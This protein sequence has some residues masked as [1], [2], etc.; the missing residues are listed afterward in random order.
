MLCSALQVGEFASK[1]FVQ[2][3]LRSP[4]TPSAVI[5]FFYGV[6]YYDES[7][8]KSRNAIQELRDGSCIGPMSSLWYGG[9]PEYDKLCHPFGS[10]VRQAGGDELVDEPWQSTVDGV[11]AQL[12]LCDQLSRNIFRGTSEAF[13]YDQASLQHSRTLTAT[14]LGGTLAGAA[15]SPTLTG[16]V[17][18]PFLASTVTALMH[19]EQVQDH[20]NALSLLDFAQE[21][22]PESLTDFWKQVR[23]MEEEHK[24]VVDRFG[25]Y[26]HRNL[27]KGR[28]STAQEE[29]WLADVENLP[30]WA[31]SQLPQKAE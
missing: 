1:A 16:E 31:L 22:T 15:A 17:Y 12:V 29:A 30:G 27:A 28:E 26:P 13:A 8:E 10:L 5:S 3:A 11:I 25:R 24:S 4:N 19:S 21:S 14:I 2:R 20:E 9:G 6:D 18:P 23:S 7:L